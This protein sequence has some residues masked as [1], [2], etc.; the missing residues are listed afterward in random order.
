MIRAAVS[1]SALR[2]AHLAL[3]GRISR[4]LWRQRCHSRGHRFG[5]GFDGPYYAAS[6]FAV[7]SALSIDQRAAHDSTS[8]NRGMSLR[9]DFRRDDALAHLREKALSPYAAHRQ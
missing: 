2:V 5:A 8:S 7:A 9:G 3:R 4:L 6:V 1:A